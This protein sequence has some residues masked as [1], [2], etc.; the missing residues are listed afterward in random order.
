METFGHRFD[1]GESGIAVLLLLFGEELEPG[2]AHEELKFGHRYFGI[3]H[4]PSIE[5]RVASGAS[6]E[7]RE[8]ADMPNLCKSRAIQTCARTAKKIALASAGHRALLGADAYSEVTA[9]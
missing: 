6:F 7:E 5:A 8:A 1:V 3:R 2:A 4:N 9:D